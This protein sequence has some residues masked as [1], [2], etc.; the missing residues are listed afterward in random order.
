MFNWFDAKTVGPNKYDY[1][2][3]TICSRNAVRIN[4]LRLCWLNK[5]AKR[6]LSVNLGNESIQPLIYEQN[7]GKRQYVSGKQ[8]Q[9]GQKM[10]CEDRQT[11]AW[12]TDRLTDWPTNQPTDQPTNW[13]NDPTDHSA[14]GDNRV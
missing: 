2:F 6:I 10:R 1:S 14:D 12:M 3:Y 11:F 13:P 9:A 5:F 8:G 7:E 4:D